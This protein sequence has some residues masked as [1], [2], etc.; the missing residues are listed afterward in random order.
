MDSKGTKLRDENNIENSV[1]V[2]GDHEGL[3]KKEIKKFKDKI[4]I[5]NQT[6]FSS[7]TFIIINNE[8]DLREL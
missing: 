8:L 3:P 4:S 5:G 7:Q 1:F 6:Y 2:I